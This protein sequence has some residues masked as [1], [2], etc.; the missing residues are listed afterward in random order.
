MNFL[1]LMCEGMVCKADGIVGAADGIVCG[2]EMMMKERGMV[3][4][5]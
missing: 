2:G 4:R 5:I 1:H 3:G